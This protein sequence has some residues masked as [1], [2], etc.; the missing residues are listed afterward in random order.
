MKDKLH[1]ALKDKS[2]EKSNERQHE[3][4]HELQI[5]NETI[6]RMVDENAEQRPD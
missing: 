6:T 5:I 4:F 2:C 3:L 1:D